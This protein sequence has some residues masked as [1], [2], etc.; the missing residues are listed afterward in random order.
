[1]AAPSADAWENVGPSD[2]SQISRVIG[3]VDSG[4]VRKIVPHPTDPNILYV[5]TAGG[6]VWK[7]FSAQAPIGVS[8]GP[9]WFSITAGIGSQSVGAFALDPNSPD[10]LYL[11]L[12]DP[13]DVHT[14][15]F[16]T[17]LDAGITW[18]GPVTLSG[19][20]GPATSVRAAVADP[21]KTG[22]V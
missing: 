18:S 14:P 6:G 5:A 7:T 22:V 16:Y 9:R 20:A 4:R 13:F 17:S 11:G 10:S 21:A 12:G 19:T 1:M 8:S 2:G 15:G 3:G